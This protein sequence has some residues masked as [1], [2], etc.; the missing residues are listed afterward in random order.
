MGIEF[1]KTCDFLPVSII[2]NR[3]RYHKDIKTSKYI[4]RLA[5]DSMPILIKEWKSMGYCTHM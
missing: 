3:L 1:V 5:S 2:S 4:M